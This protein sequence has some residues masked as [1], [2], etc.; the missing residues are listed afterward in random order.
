MHFDSH[1]HAN[2][3]IKHLGGDIE[4]NGRFMRVD[5][6][7]DIDDIEEENRKILYVS[8]LPN[9]A[10]E[11]E[12]KE[13]FSKFGKV[14]K[15]VLAKN[16]RT[17]KRTDFAFVYFEGK[18]SVATVIEKG[19]DQT[20]RGSKLEV[21][22]ARPQFPRGPQ[23]PGADRMG[24]GMGPR[25]GAMDFRGGPPPRDRPGP[26]GPRFDGPPGPPP[27][28]HDFRGPS[29]PPDLTVVKAGL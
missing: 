23:G 5:W 18:D 2:L 12:L 6:A 16:L 3:A 19:K 28:P 20:L 17:A 10:K 27:P 11:E 14:E 9:D 8:K 1:S 29:P 13:L 4:V 22:R 26:Y 25:G 7:K 21:S 24:M 15:V